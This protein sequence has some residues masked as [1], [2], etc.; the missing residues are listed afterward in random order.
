MALVLVSGI[1]GGVGVSCMV[2]NF[3]MNVAAAGQSA[4]V[5]DL[6]PSST[7]GIHFGLDPQQPLPGFDAPAAS[8]GLIHGVRLLDVSA[9]AANGDL[10]EG[11]KSGDFN[12]Q[13]DTIYFADLS[14]ASEAAVAQ[15]RPYADIELCVLAPTAECIYSIPAAV[16]E[17][18][19]NALFVLNRCDD[20]R[21]LSRHA[22]SFVRELVGERL[23]GTILSDEA[24]AEAAA[25]MQPLHR[26]S[27]ASAALADI[28]A[29]AERISVLPRGASLV[30]GP[31]TGTATSKSNAA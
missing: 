4:V 7:I 20:T 23:I 2:A 17:L 28:S 24:V 30:Q 10:G 29:L 19:D 15:L 12:F 27:P 14:G 9:P 3:A 18:P 1:R 22:A 11:L 8:N 26:H 25:M 5:L 21:R 31:V 16:A 6:S 13:G